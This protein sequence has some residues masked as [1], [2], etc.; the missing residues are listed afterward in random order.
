MP[1]F[2]LPPP[3][4]PPP[5]RTFSIAAHHTWNSLLFEIRSHLSLMFS[6]PLKHPSIFPVVNY[7]LRQGYLLNGSIQ[8]HIMFN[9]SI[10]LHTGTS[11]PGV[12]KNPCFSMIS[13]PHLT[14]YLPP[15][16]PLAPILIRF[17]FVWKWEWWGPVAVAGN[18]GCTN[19]NRVTFIW[20]C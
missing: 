12:E 9:G 17:E 13:T 18:R 1:H 8:A 20:N 11:S 15:T 10:L 16:H 6:T 3:P 14:I 7:V 4:A 5:A 19:K 2:L